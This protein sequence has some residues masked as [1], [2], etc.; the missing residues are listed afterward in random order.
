MNSPAVRT[1]GRCC[2]VTKRFHCCFRQYWA[3]L[4]APRS[5]SWSQLAWLLADQC[6]FPLLCA[7]TQRPSHRNLLVPTA[8]IRAASQLQHLAGNINSLIQ[9]IG[10]VEQPPEIQRRSQELLLPFIFIKKKNMLNSWTNEELMTVQLHNITASKSQELRNT[11]Q[12]QS[13]SSA[14]TGTFSGKKELLGC[15]TSGTTAGQT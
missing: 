9:E 10:S 2:Q 11:E 5:P 15:P 7:S 12:E 3:Q 14:P 4:R 8:L 1:V 13:V 6:W